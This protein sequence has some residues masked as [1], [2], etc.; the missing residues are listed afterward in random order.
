MLRDKCRSGIFITEEINDIVC[1]MFAD[2]AASCAETAAKLQ[3]QLN[4]VDDFCQNTG[5]EINLNKTK[6]MVFRNGGP[7]IHY[8][9]WNIRRNT[10]KVTSVYKYMGLLLT[11]RLSWNIAQDKLLSILSFKKQFGY[12]PT[13]EI[14]IL[15][16]SIYSMLWLSNMGL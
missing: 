10:I 1:L 12:F 9:N 11:P 7:L 4:I 15:F 3:Q 2:D 5:M 13:N 16:D 6:I 14:F 8:E